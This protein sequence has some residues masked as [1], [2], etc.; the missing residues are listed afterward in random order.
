MFSSRNSIVSGLSFMYLIHF[1]H[2]FVYGVTKYS[3]FIVL[4][5]AVQF[6]QSHLLKRLSFLHCIFLPPLSWIN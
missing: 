6:S 4:L 2:I 3:N 5:I 1:E